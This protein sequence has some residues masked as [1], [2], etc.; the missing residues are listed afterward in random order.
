ML[1][2]EWNSINNIL[3]F[4]YFFMDIKNKFWKR[5]KE[6]RIKNWISQEKLSEISWIH[7]T[8]ISSVERG[9]KNISLENI[10]KISIWLN[11]EIKDLFN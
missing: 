5:I 11:V 8:Y 2:I 3:Y 1:F 7:R 10:E 4:L 6:V 9:L